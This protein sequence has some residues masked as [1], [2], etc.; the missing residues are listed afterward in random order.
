MATLW[1]G[2]PDNSN[3]TPGSVWARAA[4]C[5]CD[6]WANQQGRGSASGMKDTL[7][8]PVFHVAS[9]CG[10]HSAANDSGAWLTNAGT[11]VPKHPN[12]QVG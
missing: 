12:A 11:L 5:T 6:V 10:Q 9:G 4:G 2:S 3:R 1:T 8:R 7:G